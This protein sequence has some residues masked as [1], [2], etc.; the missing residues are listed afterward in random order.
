M[1]FVALLAE[2]LAVAVVASL[3]IIGAVV[4]TCDLVQRLRRDPLSDP[5]RRALAELRRQYLR[6]HSDGAG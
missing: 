5:H 6:S 2:S 4:T 1:H 3:L